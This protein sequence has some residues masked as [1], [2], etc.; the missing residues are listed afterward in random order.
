M[1]PE[2]LVD[3]WSQVDDAT[4]VTYRDVITEWVDWH[5]GHAVEL[6]QFPP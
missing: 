6:G 5:V 2:T 3:N 4:H 1:T